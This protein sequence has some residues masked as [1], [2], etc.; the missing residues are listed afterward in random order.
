MYKC[1]FNITFD[2]Q[3]YEIGAVWVGQNHESQYESSTKKIT[4]QKNWLITGTFGT[5]E[6]YRENKEC[7]N[8]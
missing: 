4:R 6:I 5:L 8:G 3:Q 1:S 2:N 7:V